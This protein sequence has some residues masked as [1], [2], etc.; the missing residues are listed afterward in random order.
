MSFGTPVIATDLPGVRQP[1][2]TTGMGIIVPPQSPDSLTNALITILESP[3]GFVKDPRKIKNIFSPETI[4]K[5][6]E[7]WYNELL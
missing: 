5:Q 2:L 6:Y 4:A 3:D 1:I 7:E